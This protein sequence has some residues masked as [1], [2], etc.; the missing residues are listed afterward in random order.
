[1]LLSWIA[2][3]TKF[4]QNNSKKGGVGEDLYIYLL[5]AC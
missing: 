4:E 1:M 3:S 2:G 5:S